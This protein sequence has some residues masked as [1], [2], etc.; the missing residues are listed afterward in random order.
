MDFAEEK[1]E[2]MARYRNR[3]T[4]FYLEIT[5]KEM[6]GIIQ[7]NLGDFEVFLKHIKRVVEN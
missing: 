5:P 3:L 1:L 4:H 6:Y 7:H 2:K